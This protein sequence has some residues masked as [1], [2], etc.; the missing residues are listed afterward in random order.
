MTTATQGF[1][2]QLPPS[3]GRLTLYKVLVL[4]WLTGCVASTAIATPLTLYYESRVPFMVVHDGVLGGTEGQPASDTFR[5]AGIDYILSEAPVARQL[6]M[7][8]QDFAP[9]CAGGL[10]WTAERARHGKYTLPVF[11]S[12]P[13]DVIV[14]SDNPKI[15][16]ITTMNA[17]LS[18][19][20][21]T[22][23]L[24]N[25]YSYGPSVDAMLESAK[26]RLKRPSEDS[27]GRIKMVLAGMADATLFTQ[28]EAKLQIKQFGAEAAVL[29]IRH[30]SDTPAGESSYLYCSK[31]VDDAIINKLNIAIKKGARKLQ[32]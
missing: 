20:G 4:L 26:A 1:Q 21:L 13:Q 14:R 11:R 28:D 16:T 23:A 19:P 29:S 18:D 22:I 24:R 27:H 31:S 3:S 8:G 5:A 25:S 32:H 9:A 7:I 30:F 10:Y 2:T 6:E 15:Q 12:M 17:L